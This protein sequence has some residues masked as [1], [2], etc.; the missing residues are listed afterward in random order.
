ML[1][2]CIPIYNFDVRALTHTLREQGIQLNIPF[3]LLLIDDASE[4]NYSKINASLSDLSHVTYQVLENNTGRAK[5]RNL[6]AEKATYEHLLFI[7]C[8]SAILSPDYLKA[9]FE[10]IITNTYGIVSGGRKYTDLPPEKDFYFHWYYGVYRESVSPGF[11][12]NNFLIRRSLWEKVRFNENLTKYGHEDTLFQIELQ[13]IGIPVGKINNPVIHMGL[14][15]NKAFIKKSEDC[16]VNSLFILEN[17][18]IRNTE[19]KHFRLLDMYLKIK[20]LHLNKFFRYVYGFTHKKIRSS[21]FHRKP[22][23]FL[24]DVYKLL[25]ICSIADK[26]S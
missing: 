15:N 10:L 24:F 1:S 13:R 18:L 11:M 8:D 20:K 14:D 17:Q 25:Y 2:I 7:D 26:K 4:E 23:L 22:N 9:Y 19:V 6:L 21:F 3:E 16:I 12:S 5:I